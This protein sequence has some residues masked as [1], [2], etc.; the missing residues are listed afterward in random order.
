MDLYNEI[1]IGEFEFKNEIFNFDL[2]VNYLN[3][4]KPNFL[5]FHRCTF[6]KSLKI[7]DVNLENL[8]ISFTDCIFTDQVEILN[9]KFYDL[10]FQNVNEINDI[11]I[12]AIE[13]NTFKFS[14]GYNLEGDVLIHNATIKRSLHC[15]SIHNFNGKFSL[16]IN[17]F[18]NHQI[19]SS[20]RKSTFRNLQLYGNLGSVDF[21]D[22]KINDYAVFIGA[23]FDESYFN[24]SI[25]G[26]KIIFND[27]T[28]NSTV[29]F[30]ECGSEETDISFEVCIFKGNS[31]FTNAKFNTL[32]ISDTTFE[33]RVSF[34]G[35]KVNFIKLFLVTFQK[36]AFFDELQIN[37]LL[38][39]ENHTKIEIEE[40]KLWRRT[41]RQI[42]QELQKTDNKIDYNRFRSY[43]LAAYY[44]ELNWKWNDGFR[45]KAILGA[46]ILF[47]GFDNN[48]RRALAFTLAFALIFYSLFFNSENYLLAHKLFSWKEFISGYFRFLIVTDFYNPLADGRHYI[49]NTNT[50]GWL[51]FILGKIFIAFGIYEMIQAFRKFK[52]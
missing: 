26:K 22:L 25:F 34:Y 31:F 20:F 6:N 27:C 37:K 9:C 47:T 29:S 44:N 3:L 7:S 16:D 52:A 48:W 18:K 14:S 11:Y 19:S 23:V 40:A 43:E 41:L 10:K 15:S 39:G 4:F 8:S 46:T 38:A 33:S 49:D 5:R 32:S 24:K 1:S 28:F 12:T 35:L 13:V 2:D 36:L 45:D 30:R 51:I 50:I 17:S 42:K 21:E